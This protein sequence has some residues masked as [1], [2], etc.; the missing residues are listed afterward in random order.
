M[1]ISEFSKKEANFTIPATLSSFLH[2]KYENKYGLRQRQIFNFVKILFYLYIF[3]KFNQK[4]RPIV[5]SPSS[6]CG[7]LSRRL[8]APQKKVAR[9]CDFNSNDYNSTNINKAMNV[10]LMHL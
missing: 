5:R 2:Y 8:K 9:E 7:A 1:N 3:L 6:F 4:K 10:L